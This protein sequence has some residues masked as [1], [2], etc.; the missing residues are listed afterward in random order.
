MEPNPAL[1]G[2]ALGDQQLGPTRQLHQRLGPLGVTGIS[3]RVAYLSLRSAPAVTAPPTSSYRSA[4]TDCQPSL[5][6]TLTARSISSRRAVHSGAHRPRSGAAR[7]MRLY[8][9]NR[10]SGLAVSR[11]RESATRRRSAVA[12]AG[13]GA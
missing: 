5:S 2:V 7:T 6:A 10:G 12:A 8:A 1:V 3:N 9:A 11:S 4:L 13:G